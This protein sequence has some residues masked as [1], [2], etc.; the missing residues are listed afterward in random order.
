[1]LHNNS[2]ETIPV[3][4]QVC[5]MIYGPECVLYSGAFPET[6]MVGVILDFIYVMWGFQQILS[7]IT[8][9]NLFSVTFSIMTLFIIIYH[10]SFFFQI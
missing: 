8:P 1:M 2:N 4:N 3:K 7:K 10:I 6:A 9:R 5:A